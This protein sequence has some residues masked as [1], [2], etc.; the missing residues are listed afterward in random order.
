MHS[1][2]GFTRQT[3]I[4]RQ[5][6]TEISALAGITMKFPTIYSNFSRRFKYFDNFIINQR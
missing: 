3:K 1:H 5:I 6:G 4:G 2:V